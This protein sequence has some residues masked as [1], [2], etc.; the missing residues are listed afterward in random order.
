MKR[1]S[2]FL[3]GLC[4][5]VVA[6]VSLVIIQK[7]PVS[8]ACDP[9]IGD[10]RV[11]LTASIPANARYTV[12]LRMKAPDTTNNSVLVNVGTDYCG[13]IVGDSNTTV[14]TWKWVQGPAMTLNLPVGNSAVV[15]GGR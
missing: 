5:L 8:A 4:S 14:N 7:T 2:L 11:T 15:I 12:W 6:S 9:N 10:G 13:Q 3:L 1:S